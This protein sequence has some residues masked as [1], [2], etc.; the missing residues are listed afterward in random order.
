[1]SVAA[2]SPILPDSQ[3]HLRIHAD[4]HNP[5]CII[6]NGKPTT[7]RF[8]V[9]TLHKLPRPS[10]ND[11]NTLKHVAFAVDLEGYTDSR[12]KGTRNIP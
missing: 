10:V 4:K 1:V 7:W 9:P 6:Q 12:T 5:F 8:L 2:I 3:R 11:V